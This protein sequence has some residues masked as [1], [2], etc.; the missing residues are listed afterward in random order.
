MPGDFQLAY[1]T[2]LEK[3]IRG[4][5]FLIG[6]HRHRQLILSSYQRYG[7]H[8][9]GHRQCLHLG[10]DS[11]RRYGDLV[12]VAYVMTT[13]RGRPIT[14]HKL[15]EEICEVNMQLFEVAEAVLGGTYTS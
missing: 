2:L 7:Q 14:R 8:S 9:Y 10:L 12:K 15:I 4:R 13:I 6:F 11:L 5:Q 3:G 1:F